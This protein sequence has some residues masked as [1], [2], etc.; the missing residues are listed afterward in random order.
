MA[1]RTWRAA[2][3]ACVRAALASALL[4]ASGCDSSAVAPA[5]DARVSSAPEPA[6]PASGALPAVTVTLKP[7]TKAGAEMA[8]FAWYVTSVKD[9]VRGSYTAAV[10][11]RSLTRLW[12][13]VADEGEQ[14][15]SITLLLRD[16]RPGDLILSVEHGTFL[17]TSKG[18]D[19]VCELRV[20][21]D[22]GAA[23]P[24]RFAA[25]RHRAAT[26]L[27]LAGGDDARRLLAALARARVLRIQPSFRDEGSPEIEFALNGLTPA[28]ARVV[29]RSVAA[30]PPTVAAIPGV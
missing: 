17:C 20:S 6:P 10:E 1:T 11:R 5:P 3:G 12:F 13:D 19:N 22:G 14:R 4:A 9:P 8:G 18:R 16:G 25:P 24:V 2:T 28:I 23:L 29:K 7:S 26:R 21:L 30:M 15:A 27:H